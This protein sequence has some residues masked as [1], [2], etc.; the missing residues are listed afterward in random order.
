MRD[1]LEL[2]QQRY[3]ERLGGMQLKAAETIYWPVYRH[4]ITYSVLSMVPLSVVE[5]GLLR[6]VQAGINSLDEIS[7]LLGA[8][9]A[10]PRCLAI[11]TSY[12]MFSGKR[13]TRKEETA[14]RYQSLL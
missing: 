6:V 14:C 12:L 11:S 9:T 13:E 4:K 5:E 10:Y 1:S 3:G 2:L 7:E 8:G